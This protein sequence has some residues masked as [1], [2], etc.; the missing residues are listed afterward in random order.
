LHP[1]EVKCLLELVQYLVG[2]GEGLGTVD[3]A[4]QQVTVG[5]GVE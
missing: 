5:M 3:G 4:A 2:G 1:P